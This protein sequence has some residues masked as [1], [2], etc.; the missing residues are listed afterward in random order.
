MR[1]TGRI[2]CKDEGRDRV[3]QQKSRDS[4]DCSSHQKLD[5]SHGTDPSLIPSEE[6]GP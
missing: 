5:E 2:L 1:T 6:R 3:M 4:K